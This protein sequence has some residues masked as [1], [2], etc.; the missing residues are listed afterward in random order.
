VSIL[1]AG[2]PKPAELYAEGRKAER[3]GD[4]VRAYLL[5]SEAA[6]LDPS[7][8]KYYVRTQALRTQAALKVLQLPKPDELNKP[9]SVP[10]KE[11]DP[12]TAASTIGEKPA[13][14]EVEKPSPETPSEETP[15]TVAADT[16]GD[17][18]DGDEVEKPSPESQPEA[19]PSEDKPA[20]NEVEQASPA[21]PEAAASPVASEIS[22]DDL[23]E[24][25]R[26]KGPPELKP[27]PG[28]RSFNLRGTPRAVFEQ[29]AR[30]FG[31]ETV[32]DGDYPTAGTPVRLQLDAVDYRQAL[33]AAEAAT[34][35]FAFPLGERLLMV[36]KDTQ[37]KR[38]E[39]EPTI[40]VT[41]EI[42]DAVSLQDA[43]EVARGVQQTMDILKL[44]V[45]PNRRLVLI[46]DRISKVRPAQALFEQLAHGRAEVM[47]ELEFLEVDRSSTLSYGLL[48]PT[49]FPIVFFSDGV[50]GTLLN[51]A[52]FASGHITV[53]LGLANAQL[54]ATMSQSTSKTLLETQVR[55][56]DGA[57]ATFH[58]GDK[59]PIL[60]GG[61][62]GPVNF[63]VAPSYNF[64]DLG[65]LLKATPKVH[66][67][68]EVSLDVDA[69]FKVLA[70]QSLNGVPLIAMRKLQS[71]VRVKQ[72]EWAVVAGMVSAN[73]AKTITGTPGLSQIPIVGTAL[74]RNDRDRQ[75]TEVLILMKPVLINT[76][77]T[78]F[79]SRTLWV[80]SE[81]RLD[82]PL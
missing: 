80:G 63:G 66:G 53:G 20:A 13:K 73:E 75:A 8:K 64:E 1:Y 76:P 56:L 78:Q 72:G 74:R 43:Q 15:P 57:P 79:F 28:N 19:G 18:P 25:R 61:F 42:P 32:F 46:K 10:L 21:P 48:L 52:R 33:R 35:S 7:N 3:K 50:P 29:T 47:V 45:D 24:L 44:A 77:A 59:Y 23:A 55:T 82:I 69:E 4:V 36:V 62:L 9:L 67:M 65:L 31:L 58:V 41:V 27:T 71:K 60:T 51:L 81:A 5:Y 39:N 37:Q 49:Q 22:F 54:L 14:D 17:K 30:A 6:A 2:E 16:S 40:A 68:D 34:G 12:T 26:L 11:A 70:G 38:V